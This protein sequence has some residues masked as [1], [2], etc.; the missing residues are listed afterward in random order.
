ML[1]RPATSR[2]LLSARL[3]PA[4]DGAP[5][6]PQG[7]EN[8]RRSFKSCLETTQPCSKGSQPRKPQTSGLKTQVDNNDIASFLPSTF[9]SRPDFPGLS[10]KPVPFLTLHL[11][12]PKEEYSHRSIFQ[13]NFGHSLPASG[14]ALS[15][16]LICTPA[17]AWPRPHPS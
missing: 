9:P 8:S 16:S 13:E 12:F 17:R 3:A 2:F 5:Y 14:Y 11:Q 15:S 1:W 10:C 4:K 7:S 6:S